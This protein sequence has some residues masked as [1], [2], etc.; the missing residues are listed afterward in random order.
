MLINQIKWAASAPVKAA[1]I[2]VGSPVDA[3]QGLAEEAVRQ[4]EPSGDIVW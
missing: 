3:S 4:N 1:S 2:P